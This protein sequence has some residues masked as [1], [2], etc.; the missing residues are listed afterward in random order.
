MPRSGR[1]AGIVTSSELAAAGVDKST[2]RGLVGRGVLVPVGRGVFAKA[3][4]AARITTTE[5]GAR[6]VRLAAALAV[7]GPRAA[8]SHA[9]AAVI[10]GMALLDGLPADLALTKVRGSV[11]QHEGR[12][13]VRLHLA[14]LPAGHVVSRSGLLVTSPGRTVAD[15][16]RTTSFR[17]G[18]VAADS[19]LHHNL[20][21]K[22]ELASIL[23]ACARWPGVGQARKVVSFADAKAE[24]PFESISRVAFGEGGLPVP[25]LQV[26]VGGT[27]GPIGRADFLWRRHRTI[28]EA[29]GGLK[30]SDPDRAR[31]QLRRDALLRKA[32]FEVVHF[33]WR[34]ITIVPEQVVA[35][36]KTA[37]QRSAALAAAECG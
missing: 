14:N 22:E 19:A 21:T 26:W 35:A 34:E 28:A 8:A 11:G 2:L 12:S 18:V 10:H 29:D 27:D 24:S 7:A 3:D 37:F 36:I 20:V 6:T 33:S 31:S 25:E 5:R 13:G 30:Y 15:L 1:L 16:A 4:I 23:T 9:D 17:A 32:G